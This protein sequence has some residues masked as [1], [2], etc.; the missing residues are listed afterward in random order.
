MPSNAANVPPGPNQAAK[1]SIN[2][3][4]P[5]VLGRR[6]GSASRSCSTTSGGCSCPTAPRQRG[7]QLGRF[8]PERQRFSPVAAASD[9]DGLFCVSTETTAPVRNGPSRA[10]R[11]QRFPA[12]QGHRSRCGSGLFRSGNPERLR[13]GWWSIPTRPAHRSGSSGL[14]VDPVARM[15]VLGMIARIA[16]V[17]VEVQQGGLTRVLRLNRVKNSGLRTSQPNTSSSRHFP[18]IPI[19]RLNSASQ[20][21]NVTCGRRAAPSAAGRRTP[22]DSPVPAAST[23]R[24][25][26]RSSRFAGQA[27]IRTARCPGR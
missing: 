1:S 8:R 4:L 9:H 14:T 19:R 15:V 24:I 7:R 2:R 18:M 25:A 27:S 22:A 17:A 10:C 13:L 20:S 12:A 5:C 11:R 26:H 3:S 21:S 6:A 23:P 16:R